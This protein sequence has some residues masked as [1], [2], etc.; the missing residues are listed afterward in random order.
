MPQPLLV[1]QSPL[2]SITFSALWYKP[3]IYIYIYIFSLSRDWA[4]HLYLL[5]NFMNLNFSDRFW[6]VHIRLYSQILIFC[7]VPWRSPFPSSRVLHFFYFAAFI[8]YVINSFI[9]HRIF[10]TSKFFGVWSFFVCYFFVFCS[11]VFFF[12]DIICSYGI[13]LCSIFLSLCLKVS[14]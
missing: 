5:W 7:T 9:Y 10:C 14:N 11:F 12:I 13:I 4:I 3:S 6:F 2:Y 8:Y 1:S